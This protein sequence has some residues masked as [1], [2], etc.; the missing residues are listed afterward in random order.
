MLLVK[1]KDNVLS[2]ENTLT[3][4]ILHDPE[5]KDLYKLLKQNTIL[6]DVA[7]PKHM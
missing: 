7:M 5:G 2:P 4:W 6:Y 1:G 3:L